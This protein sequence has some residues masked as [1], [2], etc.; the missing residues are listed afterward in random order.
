MVIGGWLSL[1]RELPVRHSTMVPRT[2]RGYR[3]TVQVPLR[4]ESLA[5]RSSRAPRRSLDAH[6]RRSSGG[7][8]RRGSPSF[9]SQFLSHLRPSPFTSDR[10]SHVPAGHGWW[11]TSVNAGQHCWKACDADTVRRAAPDTP[12]IMVCRNSFPLVSGV[13]SSPLRSRC[14]FRG[15]RPRARLRASSRVMRWDR[16]ADAAV[17]GFT[18]IQLLGPRLAGSSHDR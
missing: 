8:L 13:Q 18:S 7:P 12:P 16:A 15:D 17:S 1:G 2:C 3:R 6:E 11:R 5:P 4:H 14:S 10:P 9:L